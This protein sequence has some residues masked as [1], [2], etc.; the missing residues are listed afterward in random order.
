[1]ALGWPG[2]VVEEMRL[3]PVLERGVLRFRRDRQ[4]RPT[5]VVV[6]VDGTGFTEAWLSA[7]EAA[8]RG[9]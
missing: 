4:G 3:R 8:Q 6:D 2:A 7:V 1:M 9:R 5:R